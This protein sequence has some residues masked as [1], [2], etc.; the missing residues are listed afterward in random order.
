MSGGRG[1]RRARAVVLALAGA[2]AAE[3][4]VVNRT[5]ERAVEAAAL[6]GPAGRV[7]RPDDAAT[8]DLVVDATPVGM[9]GAGADGPLVAPSLLGPGQVVADLVY[10]PLET[11]WLAAAAARGARVVGGLGMLVHQAAAQLGLWTGQD[12]PLDAMWRAVT[13]ATAAQAG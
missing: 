1:R 5:P 12:P 10:H 13:A 8:A 4:V 6:A 2:G 11:P 7:G 3:V 9:A